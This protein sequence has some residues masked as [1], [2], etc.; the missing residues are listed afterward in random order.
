MTTHGRAEVFLYDIV[1]HPDSPRLA[2]LVLT[3]RETRRGR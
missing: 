2:T 3:S 1:M